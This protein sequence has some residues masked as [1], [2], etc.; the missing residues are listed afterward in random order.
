MFLTGTV[1]LIAAMGMFQLGAEM[2]ITPWVKA[3]AVN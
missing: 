1:L 3:W 2:A